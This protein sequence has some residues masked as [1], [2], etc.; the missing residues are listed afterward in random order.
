MQHV[1]YVTG[2]ALRAVGLLRALSRVSWGVTPSLLLLVYPGLIR[3]YLEWGAPLLIAVTRSTLGILEALRLSMRLCVLSW[4]ACVRHRLRFSYL[5]QMSLR[6]LLGGRF[7]LRHAAWR[8]SPL[9][10]RLRLLSERARRR[11]C[12]LNPKKCRLLAAYEGARGVAEFCFR[13]TQ[14]RYFDCLSN[15]TSALSA[16]L[17]AIFCALKHVYRLQAPSAVIFTDSLFS[18]YHLRDRLSS[19]RVSPFAYKIL[20]LASLIR[21]RGGS[22]GFAWVPSHTSHVCTGC[23][24]GRMGWDL[25][26]GC[27]CG[28]TLKSLP[29]LI[30][31]CSIFSE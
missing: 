21:D 11:G 22:V 25:D 20:H 30:R 24:F 19:F 7:I 28:A 16:K 17:Y 27:G 1:K 29:H 26:E 5:G 12:R 4:A 13:S 8:D 6:S 14:P 23:H 15:F 3:S 18:L 10:L 2:R 31:E 9:I